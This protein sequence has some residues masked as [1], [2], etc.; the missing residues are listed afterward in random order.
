MFNPLF[1][2][3]TSEQYSCFSQS[4]LASDPAC[5]LTV[6]SHT[7]LTPIV[8]SSAWGHCERHT[9]F[10]TNM[11]QFSGYTFHIIPSSV[12]VILSF[13]RLKHQFP[14]FATTKPRKTETR[15]F[16]TATVHFRSSASTSGSSLTA[17]QSLFTRY[18]EPF[19]HICAS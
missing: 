4:F 3:T 19:C 10:T 18:H 8:C 13:A 9:N 14:P 17:F 12:H 16:Q 7:M 5:V 6:S 2:T 11:E 15:S 1:L